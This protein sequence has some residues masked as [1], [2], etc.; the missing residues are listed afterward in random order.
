MNSGKQARRFHRHLRLTGYLFLIPSLVIWLT[1]QF[2][3]I[4]NTVILGFHRYDL[5]TPKKFIGLGNYVDLF[6]DSIFWQTSMVTLTYVAGTYL[7]VFLISL[8]LALALK[9]IGAKR[10]Q[11]IFRTTFFLPNVVSIVSICVI[12]KL[13]FHPSGLSASLTRLFVSA[14][15][16]WLHYPRTSQAALIITNIWR[17]FGYFTVLFLAGLLGI[18]EEYYEAARVDGASRPRMLFN[19]TLPL[20]R[21]TVVFVII[22]CVVRGMQTFIPQFIMTRGGPGISNTPITLSIYHNAFSYYKMGRA[23]AMAVLLGIVALAF[24]FVQLRLFES[25]KGK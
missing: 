4:I 5:L 2:Y 16:A 20:L 21:R 8:S 15:V 11:G 22:L 6:R 25:E 10:L 23:S 3:P 19:I 12:W 9:S 7:P 24:T 17:E 18:P 13:I 1:F 14:P